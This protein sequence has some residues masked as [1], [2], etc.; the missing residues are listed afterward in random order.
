MNDLT[1]YGLDFTSAPRRA[2]PITCVRARLSDKVLHVEQLEPLLDFSAFESLLAR[3]GPWVA[4]IDAPFAQP[5]RLLEA[6]NWPGTWAGYVEEVASLGKEGFEK[7][8]RD[9]SETRPKGDKLHRREVDALANAV[10]PMALSYVPVGKM[11]YELA[12]RLLR[13]DLNVAGLRETDDEK[14]VLEVYPALIVRQLIGKRKYKSDTKRKQTSGM[15]EA[16]RD[17]L[18]GLRSGMYGLRLELG[19]VLVAYLLDDATGDALDALLGAVQAAWAAGRE[20]YG[21]PSTVDR[22]EGWIADPTL[23]DISYLERQPLQAR[24]EERKKAA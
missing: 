23:T 3:P 20:N 9:Y 10:S 16:R 12:P 17:L 13:T 22:L 8:L 14:T 18:A 21:I 1:I 2:K 19:N 7:T 15:R 4:G 5:R 24:G 6:L 11:F